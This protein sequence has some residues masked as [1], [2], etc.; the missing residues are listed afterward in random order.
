MEREGE[1]V[2]GIIHTTLVQMIRLLMTDLVI[3]RWPPGFWPPV[4]G[5]FVAS[6]IWMGRLLFRLDGLD[7][8][9]GDEFT[10]GLLTVLEALLIEAPDGSR[11]TNLD[12]ASR[13]NHHR[14]IVV[15]GGLISRSWSFPAGAGR[16]FPLAKCRAPSTL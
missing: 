13:R 6:G 7:P 8:G 5:F 9:L 16:V 1:M 3:L 15:L 14:D 11:V 2:A 12:S 4:R 10:G